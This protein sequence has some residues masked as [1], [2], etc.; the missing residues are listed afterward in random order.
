[1]TCVGSPCVLEQSPAST[2]S[3]GPVSDSEFVCRGA[4]DGKHGNANT[5]SISAQI[6]EK[7]SLAAGRQSVFRAGR[8]IGWHLED[9][10]DTLK[11]QNPVGLFQVVGVRA[12]RIRSMQTKSGTRL[13]L[14]DETECDSQGNHHKF[15]AHITPCRSNV[16][17]SVPANPT[18]PWV[19]ILA[20]ELAT[21]FRH[22]DQMLKVDSP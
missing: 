19:R 6:V 11:A 5:G 2:H 15:H 1:M 18:D 9:V 4:Y 10:A 3:I 20:E 7:R 12:S 8:D 14:I 21:L 22:P 17:V 16:A 13:C